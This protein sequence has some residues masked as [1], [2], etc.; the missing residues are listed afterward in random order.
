[1]CSASLEKLFL[2][3][4]D[5]KK[6]RGPMPPTFDV[7]NQLAL[8]LEYIHKSGLIHRDIKQE[9]VLIWVNPE[10]GQVLMKWSDFGLSKPVNDRGSCCM[11]GVRGTFDWL[12]PE[13][14]KLVDKGEVKEGEI[15]Q[16]G[17]IKT[18]VFAEGLVFGC[19]LT[20]GL[21]PFGSRFQIAANILTNNPVNLPSKNIYKFF[22]NQ[23]KI[24]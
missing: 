4:D 15:E 14:L 5:P 18:D 17:T 7:L 19:Y 2:S 21:H 24:K 13:L 23:I 6:Y 22:F 12:A 10:N 3:N 11:S 16:R 1:L 20:D 8:G 9:N